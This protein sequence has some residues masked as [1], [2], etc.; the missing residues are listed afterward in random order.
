FYWTCLEDGCYTFEMLDTFGDGWN[1][2]DFTI[3][4][5]ND[6]ILASGTLPAP[7]SYQA[8]EFGVNVN[9]GVTNIYGCT[10][11]EAINY[12]PAATED[13]GSCEYEFECSV[14]FTVSP[15]TTGAQTI[16]ITPSLNIIEAAEVEWD[17]G[18]GTMSSDLVPIPTYSGEGPYTRCLT[19]YFDN[20][21]GGDREITHCAELSDEMINP[22]GMQQVGFSVNV[23]DPFNTTGIDNDHSAFGHLSLVP[24][25]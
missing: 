14:S 1:G 10:D 24:T 3:L 20:P 13:D 9:C 8:V 23:V 19:A 11:P 25:P 2:A 12:N 17:F 21:D 18:D 5:D 6:N 15:D 22:P 16:W 4:D 7:G